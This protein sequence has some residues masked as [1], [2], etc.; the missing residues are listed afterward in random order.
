[1]NNILYISKIKKK[2]QTVLLPAITFLSINVLQSNINFYD[3]TTVLM[4]VAKV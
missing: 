3:F 4:S 1:M 2:F